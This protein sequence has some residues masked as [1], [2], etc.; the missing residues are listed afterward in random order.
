MEVILLCWK[1]EQDEKSL[2]EQFQYPD[3]AFP[4]CVWPDV[5]NLFLD[6]MVDAHWHYD[7]EY[8]YVVSGFLDYYINDT[9]LRLQP[10]DCVFVNS[11]MLHMIRQPD[12][13]D[14]AIV[15][16]MAFPANLLTPDINSTLYMKYLQPIIG[17]QLEGFK[18]N[19]DHPLGLEMAAL[20]TEL[21]RIYYPASF[22]T[23][24]TISTTYKK[25]AQEL[26]D[27]HLDNLVT[28]SDH[29]ISQDLVDQIKK[30]A[31]EG[32]D[33]G[34]E[35][36]CMK[37]VIQILVVTLRYIEVGKSDVLWHTGSL[38]AIERAR[39]VLAYMHA[40]YS[41]RITVDDISKHLSI[42]R[43]EC[44]RCFKRFTGKKPI[45]YLND[46]RLLMAVQLLR[47]TEKSIEDISAECGFASASF[48]GKIFKEK[49]RKTPLQ[50]RKLG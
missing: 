15:F 16:T 7:F 5:Y 6:R 40:H 26:F 27:N 45:E 36:E 29:R 20:I 47:E 35:L 3:M 19:S 39:E 32:P 23:S 22:L 33:F 4:F 1:V 50:F 9:Y 13:C 10:G 44:F 30:N 42:S 11:N 34:Y 14:N 24:E 12:D 31:N 18:I 17:T 41:E 49:Y 8:S 2:R 21:L 37:R 25:Y 38:A 48:F 43:N 46:H 28:D